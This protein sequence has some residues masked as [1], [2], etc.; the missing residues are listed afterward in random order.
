LPQF[1]AALPCP[2]IALPFRFAEMILPDRGVIH[3]RTGMNASPNATITRTVLTP[4]QIAW[5]FCIWLARA[6]VTGVLI[7]VACVAMV[8]LLARAGA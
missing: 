2:G 8:L 3:R 4:R 1:F 6:A 5:D 7:G